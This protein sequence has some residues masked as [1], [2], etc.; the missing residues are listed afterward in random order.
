MKDLDGLYVVIMFWMVAIM[1]VLCIVPMVEISLLEGD[2][3]GFTIAIIV[4]TIVTIIEAAKCSILYTN[5][6]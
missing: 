2:L 5:A 1:E 4:L 3:I 6:E